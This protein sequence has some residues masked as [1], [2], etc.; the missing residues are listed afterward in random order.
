M[1]NNKVA[2]ILGAGFSK[3]AD[4]PDQAEFSALLTSNEL[5]N[6][7]DI[8]I[9]NAIKDF[10]KDVFGWKEKREIPTLE[11]IFTFIDLSA[12]SGHHL[13]IKYKPNRLRALRRMLIYRTFQIIDHRFKHSEDI[14][15]LLRHYKKDDCSFIVMNWDIVLEKHLQTI[16]LRRKINY[17]TPSYDWNNHESGNT[18]DGIKICKMHGSSNWAYCENC[19]TLY[20]L[21]DEKL[22]LH[23]KVGL[24]KSDFRLFDENFTD[25]HFDTSLGIRPSEK[26]CRICNNS[27][28]SHIAT[29]SYR[30]S[31]RT[32]AYP[33]I[34]F[35]AE[36]ILANA[37][38]WIFI[39]YSL[40]EADFEL[41]HLIKSA[42]L[43]L[44]H[45]KLKRKIDVVIYHDTNT[46]N[47]FQKFFGAENVS[48]FD[49]GLSDYVSSI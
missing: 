27:V 30:K 23:K 21:L 37:S 38:K 31:F 5:D 44:K 22:S 35:E 45:K 1:L 20:Y 32:A 46:Q 8:V 33:A 18:N 6:P 25:K 26:Q 7:I 39:G 9:T 16:D 10:L 19:K 3:C 24:V 49:N 34:W 47:K 48:I 42:E 13:G 4:L 15:K 40:P 17:I 36:N 14:E 43:R 29:F 11:D 41:K 2:F 12:G 28:A